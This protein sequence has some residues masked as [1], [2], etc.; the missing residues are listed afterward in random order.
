MRD[1]M[2]SNYE[3]FKDFASGVQ[4]IVVWLDRRSILQ[5]HGVVSQESAKGAKD[6]ISGN[7]GVFDLQASF[8][9]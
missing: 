5:G 9:V 4:S 6:R 7:T 3:G 1:L 2:A 8:D